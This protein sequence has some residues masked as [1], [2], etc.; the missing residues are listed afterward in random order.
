MSLFGSVRVKRVAGSGRLGHALRIFGRL[1]FPGVRAPLQCSSV[2]NDKKA[3]S[4]IE[5]RSN[6]TKN[7][8]ASKS[9]PLVKRSTHGRTYEVSE[10]FETP[11]TF[12]SEWTHPTEIPDMAIPSCPAM[13]SLQVQEEI[14]EGYTRPTFCSGVVS[15]LRNV[16]M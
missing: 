9:E 5:E 15:H 4:E 12:I 6:Y 14:R 3:P 10:N 7:K 13:K 16:A 11:V 1:G 2:F 8:W